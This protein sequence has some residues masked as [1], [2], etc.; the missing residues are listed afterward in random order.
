MALLNAP[1]VNDTINKVKNKVESF[2]ESDVPDGVLLHGCPTILVNGKPLAYAALADQTPTVQCNN[3]D[4]QCIAQGSE[5]VFVN[6]NPVARQGDK[7]ACDGVISGGS[8]NVF[9]GSG[10][11]TFAP[12]TPEFSFIQRMIITAVDQYFPPQEKR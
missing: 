8:P 4:K 2:F 7:T 9:F 1:V 3:H 6:G 10:Q 11:G 5:T 12:I